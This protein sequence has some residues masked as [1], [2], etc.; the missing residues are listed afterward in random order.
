MPPLFFAE[1]W[2]RICRSGSG[3]G[4]ETFFGGVKSSGSRPFRSRLALMRSWRSFSASEPGVGVARMTM[5]CW[6]KVHTFV[7]S[8]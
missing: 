5:Y 8:Q 3:S 2:T 4:S 6:T 7:V 1:G